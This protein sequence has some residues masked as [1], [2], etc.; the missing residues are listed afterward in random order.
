M[1]E[2]KYWLPE[3]RLSAV[4]HFLSLYCA[5]YRIIYGTYKNVTFLYHAV[6]GTL[7]NAHCAGDVYRKTKR[8]VK[9]KNFGDLMPC[10]LVDN[11]IVSD[12]VLLLFWAYYHRRC[13][14]LLASSCS[15]VRLSVRMYQRESQ[16]T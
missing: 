7:W 8:Q 5:C 3:S 1:A 2:I 10:S 6:M 13:R 12:N 4:T 9:I 14:R 11:T 16:W 15:F